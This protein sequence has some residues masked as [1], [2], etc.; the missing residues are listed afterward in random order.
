[1]KQLIYFF[2]LVSCMVAM[3]VM[4]HSCITKT[5]DTDYHCDNTVQQYYLGEAHKARIPYTGYDTLN[6]VSN[7]G[8]TIHCIGGGKIPF[9][10]YELERYANPACGDHGIEKYYEGYKIVFTDS[11][12]KMRIELNHYERIFFPY[13]YGKIWEPNTVCFSVKN[14]NFFIPDYHISDSEVPSYIGNVNINGIQYTQ[15]HKVLKDYKDST[16]SVLMNRDIG[17]IQINFKPNETW[18][19]VK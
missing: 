12:K 13:G 1:M 11:L 17:L 16:P 8:D 5:E 15:V 18:T 4:L 6:M 9:T 14:I 7:M 2:A 19:L 3:I 10:T